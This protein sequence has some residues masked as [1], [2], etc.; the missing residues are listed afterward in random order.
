MR[1]KAALLAI[2][3]AALT[4]VVGCHHDKKH[5]GFT[6]KEECVLPPDQSRF[7]NPPSAEYRKKVE[8][9]DEKTLL[10]SNKSGGGF[11]PG[12]F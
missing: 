11:K 4:V 12:G 8:S 9:K 7:N 6:P 1:G 2:F 10:G 3:T 5:I